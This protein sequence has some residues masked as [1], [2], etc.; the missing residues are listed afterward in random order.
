M[1]KKPF[2]RIDF[3]NCDKD[4]DFTIVPFND[5]NDYIQEF[6]ND[7]EDLDEQGYSL[8]EEKGSLPE[9]KLSIV[10]MTDKEYEE[11]FAKYV[12]PTA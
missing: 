2:V 7:N 9:M 11:W 4:Y 5:V 12:E 6:Q 3:T 1:K 8:W 10:M